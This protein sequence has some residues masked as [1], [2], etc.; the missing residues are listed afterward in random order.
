MTKYFLRSKPYSYFILDP[1]GYKSED[2]NSHQVNE[3]ANVQ[4]A[5]GNED[6]TAYLKFL[7][8]LNQALPCKSVVES[9]RDNRNLK[10]HDAN[11]FSKWFC[12]THTV[13]LEVAVLA[14]TRK[15]TN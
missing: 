12:N 8:G 1:K 13:V 9:W 2:L 15:N 14:R 10:F 4:Q 6:P 7:A 3:Y 11:T 5:D